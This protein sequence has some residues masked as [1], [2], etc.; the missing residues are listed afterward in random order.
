MY[1]TSTKASHKFGYAPR[2]AKRAIT[3]AVDW[4]KANGYLG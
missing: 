3:D 4:F 1:F 2:P